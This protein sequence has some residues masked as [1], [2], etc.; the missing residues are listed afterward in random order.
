MASHPLQIDVARSVLRDSRLFGGL[1]SEQR[2]ELLRAGREQLLGRGQMLYALDANDRFHI[3]L[4]GRIKLVRTSSDGTREL[5]LFLLGPG[6]GFDVVTLLD[7]KVH[8][9]SAV[10]IDDCSILS[11]SM[12]DVRSWI[13]KYDGFNRRFLPYLGD[14]MNSLAD[15]ASS[16]ALDETHVRLAKLLLDHIDPHS[17]G[18]DLRLVHDLSHENIA[19]MIGTVRQVVNRHLQQLK[20]EGTIDFQRGRIKI[21]SAEQ[22]LESSAASLRYFRKRAGE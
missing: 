22:L 21:K 4:Y 8:D 11:T 17:K 9:F 14:Q 1:P 15:L 2:E 6:E 18:L 3:I 5:V 13:K 16:L 12:S 20:Q 7:G 19:A 10:A